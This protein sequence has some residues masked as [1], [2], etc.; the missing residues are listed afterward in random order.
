MIREL[1][2][3]N[4]LLYI[5]ALCEDEMEANAEVLG[6]D[7]H[8]FLARSVTAVTAKSD[9]MLDTRSIIAN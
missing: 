3:P 5:Q 9:I 7:F 8:V 1:E 6:L 2:V 4:S